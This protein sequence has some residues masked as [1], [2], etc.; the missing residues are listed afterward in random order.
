MLVDTLTSRESEQYDQ[1]RTGPVER[2]GASKTEGSIDRPYSRV[3]FAQ[4][5]REQVKNTPAPDP[6]T[7][8]A[9]VS[10][11]PSLEHS[12]SMPYLGYLLG[13]LACV[14]QRAVLAQNERFAFRDRDREGQW[15]DSYSCRG[16]GPERCSCR[17][18]VVL[19]LIMAV[20]LR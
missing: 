16:Q 14:V 5:E 12:M 11:P 15:R 10:D 20:C 7:S 8:R 19:L 17:A 6:S 1:L 2:T 3:G 9:L 13:S 4:Y 18:G